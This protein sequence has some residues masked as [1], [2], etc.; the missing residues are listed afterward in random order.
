M[1]ERQVV[2]LDGTEAEGTMRALG[3][4]EFPA[5]FFI[6]KNNKTALGQQG[7]PAPMSFPQPRSAV[8]L[9]LGRFALLVRQVSLNAFILSRQCGPSGLDARGRQNKPVTPFVQN[10]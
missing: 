10:R 2:A 4:K 9:F 3:A 6:G 8:G 5:L 1:A 7:G